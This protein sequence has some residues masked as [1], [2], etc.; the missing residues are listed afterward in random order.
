M[1][2][3]FVAG[4]N[5]KQLSSPLVQST[6]VEESPVGCVKSISFP[7]NL[8]S[9][10]GDGSA[11]PLVDDGAHLNVGETVVIGEMPKKKQKKGDN[12]SPHVCVTSWININLL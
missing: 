4:D 8:V 11:S 9:I 7:S 1:K 2:P 3:K 10:G 6:S 12:H 5:K